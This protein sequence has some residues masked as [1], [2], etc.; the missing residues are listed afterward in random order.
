MFYQ[1]TS[2]TEI[3]WN[4]FHLQAVWRL[5]TGSQQTLVHCDITNSPTKLAEKSPKFYIT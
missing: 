4:V 1:N 2:L 3:A 5:R